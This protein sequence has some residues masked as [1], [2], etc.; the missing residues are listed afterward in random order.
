MTKTTLNT[1]Q[2]TSLLGNL[3]DLLFLMARVWQTF[4]GFSVGL[5]RAEL[6]NEYRDW[7]LES[8]CMS[9]IRQKLG[10]IWP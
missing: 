5:K 7:K 4:S 10:L 3:V 1:L 8:Y 2:A 9:K 6:R